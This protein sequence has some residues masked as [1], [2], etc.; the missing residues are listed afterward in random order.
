MPADTDIDVGV[1]V[2]REATTKPS[3]TSDATTS[4]RDARSRPLRRVP[5]SGG[6]H[7]RNCGCGTCRASRPGGTSRGAAPSEDEG[8]EEEEGAVPAATAARERDER[9]RRDAATLETCSRIERPSAVEFWR[10]FLKRA[11]A[12]GN[13]LTPYW[14]RDDAASPNGTSRDAKR[15]RVDATVDDPIEPSLDERSELEP[16][17]TLHASQ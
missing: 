3:R 12:G 17:S 9:A 4:A 16:T 15:R 6:T 10:E 14:R 8:E 2:P 11:S 1:V 7:A 5:A 13:G